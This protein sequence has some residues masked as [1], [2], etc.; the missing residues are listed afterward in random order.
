MLR[1]SYRLLIGRDPRHRWL[2]RVWLVVYSFVGIQMGWNLR[3]FIGDP[4]KPVRFFREGVW[5]NAY[6]AVARMFW[7]ALTK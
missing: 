6:V 4:D 5:E 3:P 1:R 7:D 2:L